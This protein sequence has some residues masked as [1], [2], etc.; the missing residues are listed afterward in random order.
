MEHMQTLSVGELAERTLGIGESAAQP[1]DSL[2]QP[3]V[4][5]S[6]W[7]CHDPLLGGTSAYNEKN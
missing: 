4:L 5:A 1:K 7:L 2:G 6:E 3:Y